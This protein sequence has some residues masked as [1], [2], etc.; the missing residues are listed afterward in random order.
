MAPENNYDK[1]SVLYNLLSGIF[2]KKYRTEALNVFSVQNGE[3]IL[4]IGFGSGDSLIQLAESVGT[5]GFITG[6]DN[7]ESM[8]KIS[9]KKIIK[10]DRTKNVSL[11]YGDVLNQIWNEQSYNGI[12]MTFTLETFSDKNIEYLMRKIHL[13]LRPG[14]RICIMCMSETE[15]KSLINKLY[16]WSHKTFPR[17]IDCRPINPELILKKSGFSIEKTELLSLYGLPVKIIL[18][19]V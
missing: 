1:I 14:G 4:E 3:L 16:L 11:I 6:I 17:V 19:T 9:Q 12:L 18:A 10:K 7:S 8:N 15:K 5:S 13:W 2:E